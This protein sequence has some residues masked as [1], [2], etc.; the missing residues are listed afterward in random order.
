MQEIKVPEDFDWQKWINRWDKM[1]QRYIA[2]RS[3]RFEVMA[4]LIRETQGSVGYILDLGCGTGSLM[5]EMLK[6]FPKTRVFGIDFDPTLLPLACK[7]L[8]SFGDRVHIILDDLRESNWREQICGPLDAVV[9][10]T[11]LHWMRPEELAKLYGRLAEI[12]RPGG[13]FLNADHAGSDNSKIQSTWRRRKEQMGREYGGETW[14]HF[15][16]DY[17]SSLGLETTRIRQRVMGGWEGGIEDGMPLT[18][19]FDKLKNA[20]FVSVDCFWRYGGDAIY[21]GIKE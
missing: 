9:S 16:S 1:Q 12:L 18:W 20:G 8:D 10:A 19:H 21:G 14:E 3:E 2:G 6:N 11:A 4:Q 13:I 15:W 17:M 5:L 7:R